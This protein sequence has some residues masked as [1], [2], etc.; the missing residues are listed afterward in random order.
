MAQHAK[1][2]IFHRTMVEVFDDVKDLHNGWPNWERLSEITCTI[3]IKQRIG[4][5]ASLLARFHV[6][7]LPF[8]FSIVQNNR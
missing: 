3:T 5:A 4:R 7:T 2:P 6:E 8:I 1:Q